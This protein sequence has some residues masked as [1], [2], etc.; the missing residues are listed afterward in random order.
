MA[1]HQKL[2]TDDFDDRGRNQY[3]HHDNARDGRQGDT[4]EQRNYGNSRSSEGSR[5]TYASSGRHT[6]YGQH[7][8]PGTADPRS[9]NGGQGQQRGQYDDNRRNQDQGNQSRGF[10]SGPQG[11]GYEYYRRDNSQFRS[12]YDES[13]RRQYPAREDDAP[14]YIHYSHQRPGGITPRDYDQNDARVRGH[15]ASRGRDQ[16]SRGFADRGTDRYF[17]DYRDNYTDRINRQDDDRGN[18]RNEQRG[19]YDGSN[20]DG[21]RSDYGYG[22]DYSNSLYDSGNRNNAMRRDEDD[23]RRNNDR[24]RSDFDDRNNRRQR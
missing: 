20:R 17:E 12:Y 19:R 1:H 10:N 14:S 8:G 16:Y 15:E 3:D 18:D 13:D 6:G 11:G 2:R 24:N 5:P 7:D 22:D 4:Y 23:D 21:H 9:R